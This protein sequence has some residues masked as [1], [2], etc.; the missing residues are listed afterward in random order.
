MLERKK[1][2]EH[3][4][5]L[6]AYTNDGIYRSVRVYACVINNS[7]AFISCIALQNAPLLIRSGNVCEWRC[8]STSKDLWERFCF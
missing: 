5:T 7:S 4:Q 1:D 2:V 6:F 8:I 3:R